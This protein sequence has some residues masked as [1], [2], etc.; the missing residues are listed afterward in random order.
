MKCTTRRVKTSPNR[1]GAVF[2][3]MAIVNGSRLKRKCI[4]SA[5]EKRENVHVTT[6]ARKD[7]DDSE[8]AAADTV[9]DESDGAC[10]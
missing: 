8:L 2:V 10:C 5:L 1:I 9:M 7:A 4:L 6:S 3:H